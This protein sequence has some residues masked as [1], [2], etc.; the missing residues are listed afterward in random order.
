MS[1]PAARRRRARRSL[2][3]LAHLPLL[4][5]AAAIAFPVLWAVVT[6]VKPTAVLYDLNPVAARPTLEHY[7]TALDAL[8]V[9]RL[10]LNTAVMSA[11]V[12]L[13][14]LAVATLAAYGLTQYRFRTKGVAFALLIGT[15]LVPQQALVVPHYLLVSR[16]GLLDS[17]AG[18]VL[19]QLA[20]SALAVFL[21]RQQLAG[22]PAELIESAK[23]AG[24]TDRLILLRIVVPNLRPVLVAVGIVV[25]IQTWNEYLWPLLATS[26]T[27]RATVQV[28]LRIF[29]TEQGTAWGLLMAAATLV[30]APLVVA[31]ALAQR[32]V[33]D[34]FLRSGLG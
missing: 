2:R 11:A 18:L 15:A 31:Y 14:Q 33:T 16:L 29:E 30:A 25:F 1:R 24:A 5:V 17:Y 4:T 12:A 21:L 34:A 26:G 23:L 10:V 7:R 20:S 8:S 32:R 27:E 28:G 13:G 22:F 19:P 6:S 9:A 3:A